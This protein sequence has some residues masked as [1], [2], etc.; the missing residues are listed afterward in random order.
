MDKTQIQNIDRSHYY[1][2]LLQFEEQLRDA[3][4]LASGL[5]PKLAS[6]QPALANTQN[7]IICG[8]GGSAIAG[9]F[10]KNIFCDTLDIP[11]MV[12][13][14]YDLPAYVNDRSLVIASS[15][16]GNTEET[17]SAF[18]DAAAKKAKIISIST[19]GKIEQLAKTHALVHVTIPSG[20]H[21]RQAIGY[22]LV[23]LYSVVAALFSRRDWKND[24]KESLDLIG[25]QRHQFSLETPDNIII[26]AAKNI[27]LKRM[28]IYSSEK[29]FPAALRLK[30]QVCENAKSLA[31]ANAIP[32]MTH[33]EIVGWDEIK[34]IPD[35]TLA[36]ILLRNAE[37][38]EHVQRRFEIVKEM[39]SRK[40]TLIEFWCEGQQPVTRFLSFIH[41][42]DWLSFYIAVERREDPTPIDAI[43]N[44]K[45][46]LDKIN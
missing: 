7:I 32:E 44:L 40:T 18:L 3:Q 45:N 21:P 33:N 39:L 20:L 46:E 28:V 31:F 12:N 26:S 35:S 23:T 6:C 16:S 4:R 38:H 29:M 1:D 11:I 10:V 15:Y 22:S 36:V 27:F 17:V 41:L 5:L 19:G 13:R 25:R 2:V 37:D 24:W 34:T 42:I 14:D 8:M 9:D 43:A 30:G